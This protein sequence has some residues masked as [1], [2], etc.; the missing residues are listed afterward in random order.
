MTRDDYRYELPDFILGKSDPETAKTIERLIE[1]DAT[2]R[3]EFLEMKSLIEFS[4]PKLN[5][6]FDA[7]NHAYFES[8]SEKVMAKLVPRK[9]SWWNVVK[10]EVALLVEVPRWQ[11]AGGALAT[12]LA[13]ALIVLTAELDNHTRQITLAK[14]SQ[15]EEKPPLSLI[16]TQK[17]ALG[18]TPEILAMQLDEAEAEAIM[19]IL[20]NNAPTRKQTYKVLTDEEVESLFNPM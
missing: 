1:T 7:P 19:S 8:L 13:L 9:K 16:A 17:F 6:A 10:E 20:E 14:A 3:A 2:F 5:R 12:A 18:I 15:H 4:T 11:W